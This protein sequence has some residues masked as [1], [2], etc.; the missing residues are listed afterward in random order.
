MGE[1]RK[2][3]K[4]KLGHKN[5][6][7]GDSNTEHTERQTFLVKEGKKETHETQVELERGDR[8]EN[9]TGTFT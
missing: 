1:E 5:S 6:A 9:A 2:G 3:E 7:P 8:L 4:K